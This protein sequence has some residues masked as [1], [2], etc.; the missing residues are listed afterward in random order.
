VSGLFLDIKKAF[1]TVDHEILLRKM[2]CAG[3]RGVVLNWFKSYLSNRCQFVQIESISSSTLVVDYGVPQGSVLGP[4]LFLIFINDINTFKFNGIPTAFADD[5]AFVY[6]AQHDLQLFENIQ[7]DLC[8]L[9]IW[10]NYNRLALNTTKTKYINFHL[11]N[12]ICFSRP[13][14]YHSVLCCGSV[15]CCD[16]ISQT[17]CIKYLGLMVDDRLVWKYHVQVVRNYLLR[18]VRNFYH[19]K[20]LCPGSLLR[21]YYFAFVHSKLSYGI[22][23]FLSTYTVHYKP[24][25]TLQKTFIRILSGTNRSSPSLPLFLHH[26][27]LPLKYLFIFKVLLLFF[28]ISGNLGVTIDTISENSNRAR[29]RNVAAL[30]P[31][32][33]NNSLFR[34]TFLFLGPKLYNNLPTCVKSSGSLA[35]YKR[36]LRRW[37]FTL[38][39]GGIESF[40]TIMSWW[41]LHTHLSRILFQFIF[42]SFSIY[43]FSIYEY[44]LWQLLIHC[45]SLQLLYYTNLCIFLLILHVFFI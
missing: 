5:M 11:S 12:P 15:C 4:L 13:L 9:N 3:V 35:T 43:E 25:L 7:S 6:K 37:L 42:I 38:S 30:K 29:T 41:C 26:K 21:N 39:G 19:L 36:L 2:D 14:K 31:P 20:I 33:P 28:R 32:K 34:K 45:D 1:D 17:E 16:V 40:F 24:L 22:T 23:C 10:F 8:Q 18:C 27:I 44:F